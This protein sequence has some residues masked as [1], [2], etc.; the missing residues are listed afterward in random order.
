MVAA[1]A[2]VIALA[3]HWK[4]ALDIFAG[5]T[6]IEAQLFVVLAILTMAE[7]LA[8]LTFDVSVERDWV[9]VLTGLRRHADLAET[10]SM[11]RRIDQVRKLMKGRWRLLL[12]QHTSADFHCHSLLLSMCMLLHFYL[13]DLR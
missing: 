1:S 7:K 13:Q 6:S 9:V 2:A 4:V 8:A 5:P 3:Y 10:N 12:L 11:L